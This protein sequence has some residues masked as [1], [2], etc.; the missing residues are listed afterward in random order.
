MP[1]TLTAPG[2]KAT[3]CKLGGGAEIRNRLESLGFVPG[4][5]VAVLTTAAGN[6][7]VNIKGSRIAVSPEAACKILVRKI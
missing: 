7:V 5:E 3:V 2:E 4:A 6:I 1:L